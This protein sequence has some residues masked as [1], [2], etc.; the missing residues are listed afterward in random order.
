[1]VLLKTM[2]AA[3]KLNQLKQWFCLTCIVLCT[4]GLSA[5]QL[6]GEY[7]A[8]CYDQGSQCI[9]LPNDENA[10][11]LCQVIFN[12]TWVG[13]SIG[14]ADNICSTGACCIYEG[15]Y[16]CTDYM[17]EQDCYKMGGQFFGPLSACSSEG[18]S[19]NSSVGAC[20]LNWLTKECYEN[21]P[22]EWC[23]SKGGKYIGDET[24]CNDALWCTTYYG[25]C[26]FGEWCEDNW[27]HDECDNSGGVFW[28]DSCA[29][30]QDVDICTPTVGACCIEWD[31][32]CQDNI[33]Q[34]DCYWMGGDFLGFQ[35]TCEIEGDYCQTSIGACCLFNELCYDSTLEQDCELLMEGY[36]YGDGTTCNDVTDC[37]PFCTSDINTDGQTDVQDLLIIIGDWGAFKSPADVNQDG[38]VDVADVLLVISNWGPCE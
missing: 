5:E 32:S 34:D 38:N 25:S 12:G 31:Y 1:M 13:G 10:I 11:T 8:C 35:S 7:G 3:Y 37:S 18:E 27:E 15:T 2:S 33:N 28:I 6:Q 24:T 36:F 14:C 17:A 16:E 30:L 26:C 9:E 20:C 19:C 4:S 21:Y 29:E 23:Y 22:E